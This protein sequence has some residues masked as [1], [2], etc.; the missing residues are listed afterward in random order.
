V[1]ELWLID[2]LGSEADHFAHEDLNVVLKF[3]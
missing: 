2:P 3:R 1:M